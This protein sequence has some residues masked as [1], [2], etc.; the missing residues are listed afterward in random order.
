MLRPQHPLACGHDGAVLSLGLSMSVHTIQRE[1]QNDATL[2]RIG[3]LRAQGAQALR[4]HVAEFRLGL[5]IPALAKQLPRQVVLAHQCLGMIG[6]KHALLHS[7]NTPV[8]IRRLAQSEAALQCIAVFWSQ[9]ALADGQN[10]AEFGFG[11]GLLA[12]A[13]QSVGQVDPALERFRMFRSQDAETVVQDGAECRLGFFVLA[14]R[15]Q[16]QGVVV[17]AA[18]PVRF[19]RHISVLNL[20]RLTALRFATPS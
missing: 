5:G 12:C 9:D 2:L 7:Q 11:L 3:M 1:S 20:R 8:L 17:T 14:L 18:K 6:P 16:G 19:V 15:S 10:G 4:Q 13:N